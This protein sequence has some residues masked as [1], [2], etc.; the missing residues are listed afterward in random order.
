MNISVVF[1]KTRVLTDL[2]DYNET[3]H[4]SYKH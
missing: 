4:T 2:S 3:H 1:K